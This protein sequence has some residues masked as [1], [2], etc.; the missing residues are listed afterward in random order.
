[1]QPRELLRAIPGLE[2]LEVATERELCCG[3]AGIYN[4]VQP[5]AA[6]ELGARK[7]A[8]VRATGA[9]LVVSGNPG[10]SLQIAQALGAAGHPMPVAH[11]AEVLDASIMGKRPEAL[12]QAG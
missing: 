5:A 12:V 1:M 11:V 10:C 6:A 8:G 9:D 4:L 7:A 2:L 3:S